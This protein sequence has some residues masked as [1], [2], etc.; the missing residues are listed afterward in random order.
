MS[1][2]AAQSACLPTGSFP[3]S[4][5]REVSS[6]GCDR[7]LGGDPNLNLAC[8]PGPD[9]CGIDCFYGGDTLCQNFGMLCF[10]FG[11]QYICDIP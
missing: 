7:A 5:C 1:C 2:H 8:V 11:G 10:D 6:V 9:I 3:F 4:P